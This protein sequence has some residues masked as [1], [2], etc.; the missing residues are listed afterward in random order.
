M[1]IDMDRLKAEIAAGM[2][3]CQKHSRLP[4]TIYK[5][6]QQCVFSG[7]WNDITLRCR[8]VVLDD[9]GNIAVNGFEKFF[10]HSEGMGQQGFEARKNM[11]Y[12]VTEKMDGSLIQ[13]AIWNGEFI[14]TSSGSFDSE[15]S[16]K[17]AY[18]LEKFGY[19]H[20]ITEG[21]TYLFEIIYPENRIVLDY[22]PKESMT[23]LAIRNTESG[24]E[25]LLD[26]RFECVKSV[27]MTIEQILEELDRKDYI[28]KEGFIVRFEDGHRVK[29]KYAEYMR[30]HKIVAGVNEKFVWEALRDG[31]DLES[32]LK[33]VPDELNAFVKSTSHKFQCDFDTIFL[34]AM[35]AVK[36]IGKLESRK[37][38]A[39]YVM[40][41]HKPISAVVF[42]ALDKKEIKPPIWKLIKPEA[43][44]VSFG[45]GE[46]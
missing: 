4:L 28:N 12:V 3:N 41:N 10:N 26:Q 44:T 7:G 9:E 15:Q 31:I 24:K 13:V 6:S 35:D 25:L 39:A 34:E 36:E 40:K 46:S 19:D 16:M 8:G 43:V 5:Y 1:K 18:Y 37:E 27:D 20:F 33:G 42:A 45:K 23:L 21:N 30:L 22:G 32:A 2:V 17:A 14:V 11:P 38:Q 29:M